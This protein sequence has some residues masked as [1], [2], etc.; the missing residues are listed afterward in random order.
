MLS[1]VFMCARDVEQVLLTLHLFCEGGIYNC[2]SRC[3]SCLFC[4]KYLLLTPVLCLFFC[5][6][7]LLNCFLC[8]TFLCGVAISQL[9]SLLFLI[10]VRKV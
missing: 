10:F 6:G 3:T 9:L 5:K 8:C 4:E 7:C 2:S 1:L